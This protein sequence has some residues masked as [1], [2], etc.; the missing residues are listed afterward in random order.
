ME[1]INNT[2]KEEVEEEYVNKDM[3]S[4]ID[5]IED[6]MMNT[7]TWQMTGEVLSKE[8]PLNSL[9]EVHLDFNVA[10]KLPPL[11]T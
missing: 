8:R 6:Q 9:L 1:L 7:K 5:K 11:I 4:R 2:K 10:S 3:I